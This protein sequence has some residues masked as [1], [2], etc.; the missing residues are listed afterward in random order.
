MSEVSNRYSI[1]EAVAL[2]K[3]DYTAEN[4]Q[5]E[6]TKPE[7]KEILSSENIID[8]P[9]LPSVEYGD[10]ESL[11]RQQE[12]PS[13]DHSELYGD[14]E[15]RRIVVESDEEYMNPDVAED[16]TTNG[17]LEEEEVESRFDRIQV[18]AALGTM[19]GVDYQERK[20]FALY[21]AFNPGMRGF[22]EDSRGLTRN[23]DYGLM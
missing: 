10:E 18:A 14:D 22:L 9:H 4:K 23:V 20:Q 8:L 2:L 21:L 19:T 5:S 6:D 13:L 15:S 3:M 11:L 7:L 12:T 17:I 1:K 16:D